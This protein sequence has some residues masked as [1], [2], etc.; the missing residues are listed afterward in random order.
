MRHMLE[1]K[2]DF[3]GHELWIGFEGDSWVCWIRG[4]QSLRHKGTFGSEE[5]AKGQSPYPRPLAS[6]QQELL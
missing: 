2:A 3:L 1:E 6:G 4:K 5:E